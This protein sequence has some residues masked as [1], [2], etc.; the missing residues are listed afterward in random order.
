M[1]WVAQN[2]EGLIQPM[3]S[4]GAQPIPISTQAVDTL[5][6]RLLNDAEGHPLEGTLNAK[7]FLYSYENIL[8]YRI[9]VGNYFETELVDYITDSVSIE[10]NFSVKEW[11]RLIEANG[12]R[13]RI[14]QHVYFGGRHLV[15]VQGDSTVYQMG[16][17]YTNDITNPLQTSPLLP[18]AYLTLPMRYERV[19]PMISEDDYMEFVT[20][21]VEI[22]FVF[23]ETPFV[24]QDGNYANTQFIIAE[25][26]ASDGTPQFIIDET[27]SPDGVSPVFVIDE[28]GNFPQMNEGIY[29][30]YDKPFIELLF[31]DDGGISYTS[32]DVREF[33]QIGQYRWRMRWYE[34]GTSRDRCYKLV[35]VSPVPIV[36]LGAVQQKRRCNDAA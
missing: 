25:A 5:F 18:N 36:V 4:L 35:C 7:G 3:I 22:D 20:E 13:N 16:A 29:Y 9:V 23:G 26:A 1:A 19:T 15:T 17:Y 32:A 2:S 24:R 21:Y 10:Y 33:S 6:Q 30:N 12:G 28:K 34:L 8:F 11:H 27:V 14:Q 31:S